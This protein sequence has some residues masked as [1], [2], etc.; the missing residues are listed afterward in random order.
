[1]IKG[2]SLTLVLV[3]MIAFVSCSEENPPSS[4][5]IIISNTGSPA[6]G[7]VSIYSYPSK[8]FEE[9]AYR[10]TSGAFRATV[11]DAILS[12]GEL[13]A[14][15]RD[16]SPGPDKIEVIDASTWNASRS[17]NLHLV[18]NFTRIA[19]LHDKLFVAGSEFSGKLH[20]LVFNKNTLEKEDSIYLR[21]YVEIR[22]MIAH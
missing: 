3:V 4:E 14:I 11:T 12:E 21:D 7:I 18:A 22:K 15:K 2:Q 9:Q 17:T 5:F 8:K 19:T 13:Y 6:N 1:M 20:L 16:E 10:F